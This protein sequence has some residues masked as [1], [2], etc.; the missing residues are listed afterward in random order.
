[1]VAQVM[2]RK[3]KHSEWEE[4]WGR[5]DAPPARPGFPALNF[6]PQALGVLGRHTPVSR[7]APISPGGAVTT[8]D[9]RGN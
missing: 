5:V 9:R 1:M 2:G 3:H 7:H 6:P 4:A 8:F